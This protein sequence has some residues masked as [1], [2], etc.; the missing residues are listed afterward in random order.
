MDPGHQKGPHPI[1]V[2][3]LHGPSSRACVKPRG[4]MAGGPGLQGVLA[5]GDESSPSAYLPR[6]VQKGPDTLGPQA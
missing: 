2:L 4:P 1:R 3:A 6:P 5:L